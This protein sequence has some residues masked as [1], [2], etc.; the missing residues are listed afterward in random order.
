MIGD[1]VWRKAEDFL[2][3]GGA[4]AAHHPLPRPAI[5][6]LRTGYR[7]A[8]DLGQGEL[9]LRATGLVYTTL[10]A[11]VP[12]LAVSFSVLKGFGVHEKLEPALL[13]FLQP[14]GERAPELTERIVHFVENVHVGVLGSLGM[15]LLLYTVVS[16]L[17][18]IEGAFNRVWRVRHSRSL[19]RRFSD[20]LSVL[21][22][23]PFLVFLALGI[24][25]SVSSNTLV[26][27]LL[28]I[29]PLGTLMV[30]AGKVMPYLLVI[31]AFAFV[32]TYIPNTRVRIRAALMGAAVGGILWQ[33]MGS[34]FASFIAT[35]GRYTAIYSG[36]AIVVL[37]MV[38]LYLS[39]LI[40]LLGAQVAFYAQH[41]ELVRPY[42]PERPAGPRARERAGLEVMYRVVGAYERGE[43]RWTR[44]HLLS[45]LRMPAGLLEEVVDLL[46]EQ[47]FL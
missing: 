14:L 42:R 36:F 35:S 23:G 6:A 8:Q 5:Y 44:D 37:F 9:S 32:Y 1:W 2:W 11:L 7:V 15:A 19:A 43:A 22:V 33:T 38:W 25:A 10:L 41:P 45:A 16:L 12:A 3:R 30:W 27:T 29:E 24:T 31:A 28:A 26:Q 40:L 18:K 34:F 21:L 46:G 47:G 13:G 20:F 39:W 17:Q 4:E